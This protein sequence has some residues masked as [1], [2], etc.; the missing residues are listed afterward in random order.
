[1]QILKS[2]GL[3]LTAKRGPIHHC[4]AKLV[5]AEE[6]RYMMWDSRRDVV[7][8]TQPRT[9]TRDLL[10]GEEVLLTIWEAHKNSDGEWFS[11]KTEME[12]HGKMEEFRTKPLSLEFSFLSEEGLLNKKPYRYKVKMDSWDTLSTV[13][14]L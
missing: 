14:I 10:E 6:I 11:L 2:Q 7:S 4:K 9:L 8:V 3:I 1:M 13:A 12:K 5:I